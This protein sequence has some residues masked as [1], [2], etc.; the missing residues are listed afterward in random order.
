MESILFSEFQKLD[1]RV[2]KVVSAERVEG[3]RHLLK[4]AVDFGSE[5]GKLQAVSGIGEQ[6]VPD[7]LIGKKFMFILNLERKKFMGVES[8]C[9]IFAAEDGKGTISLM[10]PLKDVKEGSKVH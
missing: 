8:Q 5:G 10:V 7:D 2:G 3:S 1:M 9:M 4:L 6:Y